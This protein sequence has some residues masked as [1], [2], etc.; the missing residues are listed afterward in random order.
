MKLHFLPA[1]TFRVGRQYEL[2]ET[3]RI[4][5]SAPKALAELF[6][7]PE[8]YGLFMPVDKAGHLSPKIAYKD[9]ALLYY[10]L[11]TE[12]QLPHF[13][14]NA[15]DDETNL[16]VARLVLDGILEMKANDRFVS[17]AAAQSALYREDAAILPSGGRLPAISEQAIRYALQLDGLDSRRIAQRL[18]GYNTMPA[19]P[20]AYSHLTDSR[21]VERFL[22]V[23]T[24]TRKGLLN[25]WKKQTPTEQFGWISWHKTSARI[26][27][28]GHLPTYKIYIS[29]T[30]DDLPG[31]FQQ[32]LHI[33][34]HIKL[35]SFKVGANREGV[36]RPDKLVVYF[37]R[38]DELTQAADVLKA[39]LFCEHPQGVPFTA[40]SMRKGCCHGALIRRG[41]K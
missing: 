19:G 4:A 11:Q 13:I 23:A 35:V 15:Y 30:I 41:R 32:F 21:A 1:N 31:V 22:R 10:A 29:P 40:R 38:Y 28:N 14:R 33:L 6:S 37:N 16:V 25:G 5:Q 12:G 24:H 26:I 17:G 36:L 18:Y 39:A 27:H 34:P 20:S 8:V 2:L 9:V 3:S 7:N